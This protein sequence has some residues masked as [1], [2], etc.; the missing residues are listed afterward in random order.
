MYCLTNEARI[1]NMCTIAK[2]AEWK[3]FQLVYVKVGMLIYEK[4][5]SRSIGELS[6]IRES[7]V[8]SHP[9]SF[10]GDGRR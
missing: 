1:L 7:R 3:R 10:R 6:D 5:E 4:D 8:G 2:R 9:G